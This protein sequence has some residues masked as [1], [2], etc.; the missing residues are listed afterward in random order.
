MDTLF[1]LSSAGS[2]LHRLNAFV[3]P[4]PRVIAN[5]L[6]RSLEDIGYH[7]MVRAMTALPNSTA[8][9]FLPIMERT[10]T[11][12]VDQWAHLADRPDGREVLLDNEFLKVVLI[13]WAPGAASD[14][15]GHP[16]G[17]G[18]IKVLEGAIAEARYNTL[19]STT[20]FSE[21]IYRRQA[22][23]YID[24]TMGMHTVA[25]PFAEPAVTLHAYLKY[26]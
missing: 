3:F 13:R 24:D 17:G 15:H 2:F 1:P 18:V 10:A 23:S 6:S 4:E 7:L 19:E 21:H 12:S 22:T 16:K 14:L 26:R 11:F 5:P 9:V 8:L 25:N 20:P